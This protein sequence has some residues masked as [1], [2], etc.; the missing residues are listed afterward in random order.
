M[1]HSSHTASLREAIPGLPMLFLIIVKN[2]MHL[3]QAPPRSTV[4]ASRV[5]ALT[6]RARI[7]MPVLMQ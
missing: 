2:R 4:E 5:R 1:I 3:I 7:N 6:S